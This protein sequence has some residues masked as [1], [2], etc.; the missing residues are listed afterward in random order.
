M[1]KGVE[2]RGLVMWYRYERLSIV[3][4]IIMLCSGNIDWYALHESI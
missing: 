4:Q 1:R 2:E 3:C